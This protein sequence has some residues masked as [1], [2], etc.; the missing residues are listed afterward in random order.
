MTTFIC[1]NI[2]CQNTATYGFFKSF[3]KKTCT[4]CA[5]PM[6]KKGSSRLNMGI[7]VNPLPHVGGPAIKL[8][9]PPLHGQ[10]G[11]TKKHGVTQGAPSVDLSQLR[12]AMARHQERAKA[13]ATVNKR[14]IF[15]MTPPGGASYDFDMPIK[16]EC[17]KSGLSK[18]DL[19]ITIKIPVKVYSGTDAL[20]YWKDK[21]Y[22][23][24]DFS[25][26]VHGGKLPGVQGATFSDDVRKKWS[27][28][29]N[30]CWGKAGVIWEKPSGEVVKYGLRFEFVIVDNIDD[31][32]AGVACVSTTGQAHTINPTGTIDAVR[33]GVN[34]T[35]PDSLGPICHEV[36]HLIGN[37]DEYFTIVY[38]GQTR[39][40][41]AG[42][43]PG[44]G[45]MNNPDNPPLIRN[46]K[47]LALEL[48][49]AFNIPLHQAYV[50]ENL[51]TLHTCA[52]HRLNAHIWI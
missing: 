7:G 41:G 6:A 9:E 43:Q 8:P 3:G 14:L 27:A 50:V 35:D 49:N 10:T 22:A 52:K 32:A 16:Y 48:A 51:V 1:T 28:K 18:Q 34:D 5:H 20:Q 39:N 4:V 42:Y 46:Y 30:K 24:N 23:E 11:G 38:K 37:P 36:G 25:K 21:G 13:N 44:M 19:E 40:W 17:W 12:T 47:P 29:V 45:I 26:T 31:A 33:W 15:K 2:A